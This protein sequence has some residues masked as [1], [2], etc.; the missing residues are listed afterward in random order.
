MAAVAST[1]N[2]T[3]GDYTDDRSGLT[4]LGIGPSEVHV[5]RRRRLKAGFFNRTG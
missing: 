5:S 2:R 3:M 1:L 4:S